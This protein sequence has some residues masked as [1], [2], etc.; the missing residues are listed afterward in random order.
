MQANWPSSEGR[1]PCS[2]DL[3][4]HGL[5]WIPLPLSSPSNLLLVQVLVAVTFVV[6][7]EH[8]EVDDFKLMGCG[9][10]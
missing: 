10:M 6:V 2:T 8:F 3:D 5:L 7:V 9:A 1:C 4:F